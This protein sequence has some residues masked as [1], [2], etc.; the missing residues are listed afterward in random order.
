MT[1]RVGFT[2]F[3][4]LLA[5]I[6]LG[7]LYLGEIYPLPLA[8][9]LLSGL[10]LCMVLEI[11][12]VLPLSPLSHV[13]VPKWTLL[14]LPMIFVLFDIPLLD[15]VSGFLTF[16]LITRF[17]FK[18]ELN[19][20]LFGYLL[21]IAC[22]LIGA[23]YVRDIIFGVMF[24]GFFLV[25]CW[26]LILYNMMV[27]R[28]G[29][30]SPPEVFLNVGERESSWTALI[31]L[32]SGLVVVSLLFTVLIFLSF[33]RIG[34]GLFKLDPRSQAMTGFSSTVRLGD[35]GQ[36]KQNEAV[37]MRV[38][39][40]RGSNK[41][42]PKM[43]IYWRGIALDHYNGLLWSSRA[44][45]DWNSRN[46]PGDGTPVFSSRRQSDLVRQEVFMESF[47]T[48]LVFT[49]GLPY[50]V[51]GTFTQIQMDENYTLRTADRRNP[52]PKKFTLI[53]DIS[54]PEASYT[55]PMPH[56][57][58]RVFPH[59]YLQLP[60]VDAK[61][62]HL[63]SRIVRDMQSP[64]EKAQGILEHFQTGFDYSLE[65]KTSP[66]ESALEHFLFTRKAGHCEYFASAMVV[67]LRLAGVPSRMVN[68][69]TSG[70]WNEM[71]EY[72]IIRQK[73]AHS[74]VE[75]FLPGR[76]W[77]IFDPTPPDPGLGLENRSSQLARALDLMRLNWQRYVI[78][79]S[80]GD[81]LEILSFFKRSGRE[82]IGHAKSF[83]NF[84]GAFGSFK[85]QPWRPWLAFLAAVVALLSLRHVRIKGKAATPAAAALYMDLLRRLHKKGLDKPPSQ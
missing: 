70:E 22:L 19:D 9:L 55:E 48:N 47:D 24:L 28:A 34:L 61:I 54:R 2:V 85:D 57:N 63:A 72:F 5:G 68:G 45:T 37:V 64:A 36:I 13:Q 83:G 49:H 31:G 17:I 46:R 16:I 69:F 42:M 39:Y 75:A 51:D 38:E 74:W 1:L 71:G 50:L 11:R 35:V 21:S 18:S 25:L 60:P 3:S 15:F 62:K 4:Y 52:G 81:Q 40:Y 7:C 43:P 44:K 32:S 66:H 80:L 33:P 26:S 84:D 82:M 77:V 76:G 41:V 59:R 56:M 8:V 14:A 53:S 10:A 73:H 27:E 23:I 65:M 79:Y 6:G 78:K 30:H 29:S 58:Q 67:L 12:K 20:Y